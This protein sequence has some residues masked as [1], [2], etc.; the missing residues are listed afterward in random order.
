ML[1]HAPKGALLAYFGDTPGMLADHRWAVLCRRNPTIGVRVEDAWERSG[2]S[3]DRF[4]AYDPCAPALAWISA[5]AAARQAHAAW[6]VAREQRWLAW[7]PNAA[8]RLTVDAADEPLR[9]FTRFM[10]AGA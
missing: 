10:R 5:S 9:A 2:P 1:Q 8:A 6:R 4:T 3:I 7:W